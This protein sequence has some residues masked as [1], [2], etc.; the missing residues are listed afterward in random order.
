MNKEE[1]KEIITKVTSL[2]KEIPTSMEIVKKGGD[3]N[4]RF[5]YLATH[6]VEKAIA[7][8]AL[9]ISENRKG[10]AILFRTN[11]KDDNFLKDIK[12]QIGLVLNVTG[13]KNA[14][15]IVK[16]Q[17]YIQKK[18]PQK[19]DYLYCWFWGILEGSRGADT[20]VGKEMKDEF[21][22][23][24]REYQIPLYAETR[25]RKNSLVYQ[26]FGFELF[27]EWQHPSGDTMYFLR[28]NPPP[29]D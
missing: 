23:Q 17:S 26:R 15:K 22:R 12:T 11:K 8:D 2:L 13:I 18:R 10:I 28:Y 29:K 5:E 3:R 4:K 16:T 27:H 14:F 24:A 19:G 9:I 25:M 21:Y 20:Q 7:K 6:M 1:K